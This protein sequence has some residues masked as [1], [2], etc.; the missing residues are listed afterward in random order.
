MRPFEKLSLLLVKEHFGP[1]A[2]SLCRALITHGPLTLNEISKVQGSP[3]RSVLPVARVLALHS[4]ITPVT[5][6]TPDSSAGAIRSFRFSVCACMDLLLLPLFAHI[7]GDLFGKEA[8]YIVEFLAYARSLTLGDL[9]SGA[10]WQEILMRQYRVAPDDAQAA[11]AKQHDSAA[12]RAAFPQLVRN[13]FITKAQVAPPQPHAPPPVG[14]SAAAKSKP[15]RGKRRASTQP[16]PKS[17][18]RVKTPELELDFDEDIEPEPVGETDDMYSED[19]HWVINRDRFLA[20][21]RNRACLDFFS[22]KSKAATKVL[23]HLLKTVSNFPVKPGGS[24]FLSPTHLT[25]FSGSR[26]ELELGLQ[27]LQQSVHPVLTQTLNGYDFKT[28][29]LL[30]LITDRTLESVIEGKFGK[31]ALRMFRLL[32]S[33]KKLE[34]KQIEELSLTNTKE[35]RQTLFQMHKAGLIRFQPIP[36]TPEHAPS[37]TFYLWEVSRS[38]ALRLLQAQT[39]QALT[40]LKQRLAVEDARVPWV[41]PQEAETLCL[42]PDD[43]TRQNQNKDVLMDAAQQ[44][45]DMLVVLGGFDLGRGVGCLCQSDMPGCPSVTARCC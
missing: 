33:K 31:I 26:Q 36:K 45:V 23:T 30:R 17:N 29:P 15:Q 12:V 19:E 40:R 8:G 1:P 42:D 20:E 14:A 9:L 22:K 27:V 39:C 6:V 24:M 10:L 3:S 41:N 38:D 35:A 34:L 43:V 25:Q 13:R 37:R 28:E 4:I 11:F 18:K 7:A 44:L 2:E 16:G 21:V 5:L 32:E